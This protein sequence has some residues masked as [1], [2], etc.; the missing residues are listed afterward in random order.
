MGIKNK[1]FFFISF[2]LMKEA[3]ANNSSRNQVTPLNYR[4]ALLKY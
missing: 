1:R 2:E 3:A 4:L